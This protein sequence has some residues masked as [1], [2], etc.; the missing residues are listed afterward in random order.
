MSVFPNDKKF[1]I[2]FLSSHSFGCFL[3]LFPM[4]SLEMRPRI[5]WVTPLHP[6]DI[7]AQV[8]AGLDS[9]LAPVKGAIIREHLIFELPT[10]KQHF[11]SPRMEVDLLKHERGTL[12]SGLMGPKP[13]VWVLFI[14]IYSFLGFVSLF[15]LVSGL[16]DWS[17]GESPILLLVPTVCLTAMLLV[18]GAAQTGKRLGK[19]E[20]HTL[21]NFL[22]EAVGEVEVVGN[23]EDYEYYH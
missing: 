12:I 11:W 10:E 4:S 8:R 13:T 6:D 20:M 3:T 18:Y 15:G 22:L 2:Y 19:E 14:F 23:H 17:L 16:S 21:R 7:K 1:Y 9:E 5:R